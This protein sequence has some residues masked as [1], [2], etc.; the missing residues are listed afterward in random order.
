[1]PVSL[2]FVSFKYTHDV[3][4]TSAI[5]VL[6]ASSWEFGLEMS[7]ILRGVLGYVL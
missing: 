1:M 2:C 3:I 4:S 5:C 6:N 7:E